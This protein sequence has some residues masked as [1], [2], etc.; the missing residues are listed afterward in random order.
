MPGL[1]SQP[2][3]FVLRLRQRV[4]LPEGADVEGAVRRELERVAGTAVRRGMRMALTAG[5]RGIADIARVLHAAASW[6]R[7]REG[8]PFVVAAMGSHG[9]ATPAGQLALLGAYGVTEASVGC[10]VVA[11]VETA[12]AGRTSQGCPATMARAAWEAD[13]VLVVNRVKPHTILR[14]PLGSGLMKMTAL[15]LSGPRGADA[16]HLYGLEENLVPAA[17]ILLATGK[18]LVGLALVENAQ[19]R[20]AL[21]EGVGAADFERRDRELLQYAREL[22]PTLPLDPLDVLVVRSIGKDISGA[23]MD[24]NVIGMHRRLGGPPE[25]EIRRIVALELSPRSEGN[26]IG[27]GVAD[28]ITERLR[29]AIDWPPTYINA[30]T[31]DFL[32]GIKQPIA[33]P[34]DREAIAAAL[35]PFTPARA[36]AVFVQDTSHLETLYVTPALEAQVCALPTLTIEGSPQ[37]LPFDGEGRLGLGF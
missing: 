19:G 15:G 7:E 22:M 27:V 18:V 34:T 26:A 12:E 13:G 30:L 21:V 17:R 28:I 3:P 23:G 5:S 31:S 4:P 9:G 10:P 35:R 1:T 25:R 16:I 37:P 33:F 2:L 32:W 36:R 29:D 8:E 11:E 24:P 14:P 6:V 20:L